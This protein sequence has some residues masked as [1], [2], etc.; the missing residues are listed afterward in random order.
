MNFAQTAL[1]LREQMCA[2]LGNLPVCKTARRFALEALYGIQQSQSLMLS[3]IA[4]ALNETIPLIKTENR[5]SRQAAR[6]GLDQAVGQFVIDQGASRI[7]Q[8][9]LLVI[10]PSDIAKPYAEKMEYLARVRDG[11]K[12]EIANGYWLCQ[13]VGVERGGHEIV[14]LV[15]RLWSQAAP[16]FR[17]ENAQILS[18]VS[19]VVR[20]VGPDKGIWVMDRGGDRMN[21]FRAFLRLQIKFIVRLIGNRDLL[22]QGKKRL[23]EEIAAQCPTPYA[24]TIWRERGDGTEKAVKLEFGWREVR[25]PGFARTLWLLVVKGFGEKPLLILTTEPLRQ[26][27]EVLWGVLE[28]YLTRWRIEETLRFAKQSYELEDVRVLGYQSLKNMMAM[29]LLTMYFSMV[30]LGTQAK[31]TILCHHAFKAAKRL[32]G[33]PDFRYYAIADGIRAI[34][35]GRQRPAFGFASDVTEDTEPDM[36][37]LYGS[38]VT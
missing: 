25:L 27:R 2:F 29:A 31:L 5:L 18:C 30:Y 10:D 37:D 7:G 19:A 34:L 22:C 16:D 6:E 32:F 1:R 14:P 13:V 9:T 23:A 17:S 26:N 3:R 20:R 35:A 15:N 8:R 36:L 11:S 33:I 38:W 4:R 24:E 21:L 12:K 28:A